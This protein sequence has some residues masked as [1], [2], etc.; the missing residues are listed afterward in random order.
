Q[1][2]ELVPAEAGPGG[3][4]PDDLLEPP[5]QGDQQPVAG[6]VA[7]GVVDE[8]EPVQVQEQHRHRGA[9][10]LGAGQGQGNPVLEEDPVGQAGEGVVGGLVGQLSLGVAALDGDVGQV[11]GQL[12]QPRLG[13]AGS[14]G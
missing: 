12:Q 6:L 5:A 13:R 2:G 14:A 9:A 4:G 8:L 1:D 11:G 7:Q 10:A 3:A